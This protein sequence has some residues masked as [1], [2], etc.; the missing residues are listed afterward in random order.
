MTNQKTTRGGGA[1]WGLATE[2]SGLGMSLLTFIVVGEA[3]GPAKFGALA[4]VLATIALAGPLLT[5][6]PEHVLVQ[7]IAQ[8]QPVAAAWTGS[9]GVLCSVGPLVALAMVVASSIIAPTVS[10][11]SIVFLTLGEVTFLGLARAAI[12]A[13]EAVGASRVGARVAIVNLLTRTAAIGGFLLGGEPSIDLWV[14][15]HALAAIA[16]AVHAHLTLRPLLSGQNARLRLPSRD[17][18][19]LGLPFALNAGPDGLLSNND[20]MVLSGAGL[21][22]DAG[23][24]AAAYRIAS[25]AGVPAR[26]V[27]RTRYASYFRDENQSSS[28]AIANLR[29]ILAATVPAGI[30]SGIALALFAPATTLVMGEDFA[31]SVEALRFLA[32]LPIVRSISTPC[33]N[34][35]TGTGRQRLRIMGTAGAALLNLGLNLAF[36]PTYGWRAAAVTTLV[37]EIALLIWVS[38]MVFGKRAD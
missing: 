9:L 14:R 13:H 6:S 33:A 1:R 19:R 4:A 38:V 7:R 10:A 35:L 21:E 29:S 16:A 32:F 25:I 31:D 23:I 30:A 2:L 28:A 15:L 18:Y 34:V 37:A 27:L 20:K 5:A 24:Y 17:D 11:L 22:A 26:S 12:R 36:I 8:G 3:L